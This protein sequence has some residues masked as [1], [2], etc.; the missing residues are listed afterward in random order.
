M[1]E[2]VPQITEPAIGKSIRRS[3]GISLIALAFHR[4]RKR[5]LSLRRCSFFPKDLEDRALKLIVYSLGYVDADG[6]IGWDYAHDVWPPQVKLDRIK[7]IAR[8][9]TF[10]GLVGIRVQGIGNEA[11]CATTRSITTSSVFV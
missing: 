3:S 11:F 5:I 2:S 6:C 7:F 8:D 4:Q 10:Y 1:K 9:K